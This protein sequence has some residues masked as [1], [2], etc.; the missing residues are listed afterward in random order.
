MTALIQ[1]EVVESILLIW[2]SKREGGK[3]DYDGAHEIATEA[4]ILIAK[5][6]FTEEGLKFNEEAYQDIYRPFLAETERGPWTDV[7]SD[8]N[9]EPYRDDAPEI[10]R[11]LETMIRRSQI[12]RA[13]S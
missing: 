9:L 3:Y 5:R 13:S 2:G 12:S 7:P 10:F 8:L 6:N 11:D 1:H 4:E